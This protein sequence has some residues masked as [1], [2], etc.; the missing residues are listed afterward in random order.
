MRICY[1]DKIRIVQLE[2]VV[3]GTHSDQCKYCKS[4]LRF[5]QSTFVPLISHYQNIHPYKHDVY[6]TGLV[7]GTNNA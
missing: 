4:L 3:R 2:L 1:A 5:S 7:L 6:F